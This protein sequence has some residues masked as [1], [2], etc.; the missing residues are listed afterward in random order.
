[1]AEPWRVSDTQEDR[2]N[3]S[4]RASQGKFRNGKIDFGAFRCFTGLRAALGREKRKRALL[5][6]PSESTLARKAIARILELFRE[7]EV[8]ATWPPWAFFSRVHDANSNAFLQQSSRSDQ[9]CCTSA[10]YLRVTL[11]HAGVLDANRYLG[12]AG[13]FR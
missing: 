11:F 2:G 8:A 7:F 13:R 10:A 9:R 6:L 12:P 1:M 3:P 4:A 5:K